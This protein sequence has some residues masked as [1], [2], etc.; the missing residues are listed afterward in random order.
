MKDVQ[1]AKLQAGQVIVFCPRAI[2]LKSSAAPNAEGAALRVG[3]DHLRLQLS[4]VT[5][6][7]SASV[8]IQH[9]NTGAGD[10]PPTP[11]SSKTLDA[12]ASAFSPSAS[13]PSVPVQPVS[14][15]TTGG[16]LGFPQVP[17]DTHS[18]FLEDEPLISFADDAD[19]KVT[20][21]ADS[22]SSMLG[23]SSSAEHESPG[24]D[25]LASA[26]HNY[27][28]PLSRGQHMSS[29]D[30][31][32][33]QEK[34]KQRQ[35]YAGAVDSDSVDD[36]VPGSPATSWASNKASFENWAEEDPLKRF[37]PLL[38]ALTNSKTPVHTDILF[39]NLRSLPNVPIHAEGFRAYLKEAATLGLVYMDDMDVSLSPPIPAQELETGEETIILNKATFKN[40][41]H[42]SSAQPSASTQGHGARNVTP[43]LPARF[44]PL[45]QLLRAQRAEGRART[46]CSYIAT[47]LR[48][49]KPAWMGK[50]WTLAKYLTAAEE[51][52][53][54]AVKWNDPKDADADGW[55]TLSQFGRSFPISDPDTSANPTSTH[56]ISTGTAT[57]TPSGS[58]PRGSRKAKPLTE[59]QRF[60]PLR[61]LFAD[62]RTTLNGGMVGE[63][64]KLYP[65]IIPLGAGEVKAYIDAAIVARVV[66]FADDRKEWLTLVS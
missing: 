36:V 66:Q 31:P 30:L 2:R 44:V 28:S 49:E 54:L 65:G 45:L 52:N 47:R 10:A 19:N 59:H 37:Q 61:N 18:P 21:E 38:D 33:T 56:P 11:I 14:H 42:L 4:I 57:T 32:R 62:G 34:G 7:R 25:W 40:T 27:R 3:W 48:K 1:V 22:S 55:V 63:I 46:T 26:V 6:P 35:Q 13:L 50:N 16:L 15:S 60:E 51:R 24:D 12:S 29:D 8:P 17:S 41:S 20:H 58:M 9:A 53:L 64:R 5:P 43:S 39:Y 23:P